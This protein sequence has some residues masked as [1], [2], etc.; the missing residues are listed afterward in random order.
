M[1][2]EDCTSCCFLTCSMSKKKLENELQHH[3]L[4]NI[5]FIRVKN[6][7]YKVETFDIFSNF[8]K[9]KLTSH[10]LFCYLL[11]TIILEHLYIYQ[12]NSKLW[13][14]EFHIFKG[15][16]CSG[17]I[18]FSLF[19]LTPSYY[20]PSQQNTIKKGMFTPLE[21]MK[22]ENLM[23]FLKELEMWILAYITSSFIIFFPV[24]DLDN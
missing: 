2:S 13:I 16:M 18:F 10:S 5:T 7:C 6:L 17:M 21:E 22:L 1:C 23:R 12:P 8:W 11:E 9:A 3:L 4:I 19:T 20:P 14:L 24:Q 15:G